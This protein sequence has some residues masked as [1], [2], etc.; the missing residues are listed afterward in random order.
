MVFKILSQRFT[1]KA[2]AILV[3]A[4]FAAT[5]SGCSNFHHSQ[6]AALEELEA[7]GA[8]IVLN[9]ERKAQEIILEAQP[10]VDDDLVH[11]RGLDTLESLNLSG[12]DITGAGLVHLADLT[13][14]KK[15]SIGGGYQKPSKVGDDGLAHLSNLSQLEQLV[16]SDTQITDEGLAHLSGLT[17][18]K[19]LYLFQTRITDAG[20]AHL[21]G[22]QSLEILR[23]ARTGITEEGAAAFQAKMPNLTK[24][25]D[26][27]APESGEPTGETGSAEQAAEE[28]PS[29]SSEN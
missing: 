14:L 24:F 3:I 20:L 23:A 4:L 28:E 15:L 29:S 8:K 19:S 7:L 27:P 2:S 1:V 11:L 13:N 6:R 17:N 12:T 25:M 18:L 22:L 9:S 10:I 26:P 16:L 21:E 5:A